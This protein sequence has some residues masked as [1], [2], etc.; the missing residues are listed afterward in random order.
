MCIRDSLGNGHSIIEAPQ[1]LLNEITAMLVVTSVDFTETLDITHT[2]AAT[3]VVMDFPDQ[4]PHWREIGQGI[5][6]HPV[7]F[8]GRAEDELHR[9]PRLKDGKP[10]EM[11][12]RD[13]RC[14]SW[15][16]RG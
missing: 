15:S 3:S 14:A 2:A 8:M 4:Q 12:I 1:S 6:L 5:H 16:C 9:W 10:S 13:R 7:G 11:C